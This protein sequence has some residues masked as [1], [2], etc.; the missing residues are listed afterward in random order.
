MKVLIVDEQT[1]PRRAAA[2]ALG[3]VHEVVEAADAETAAHAIAKSGPFDVVVVAQELPGVGELMA[4]ARREPAAGVVVVAGAPSADDAAHAL[5]TG[6][7]H[8]LAKPVTPALLRAA[9]AS[10]RPHAGH[11]G[12]ALR[13]HAVQALTLNGY[14]VDAGL[15]SQVL[16]DGTAVH[17]FTVAQVV[18]GWTRE[19]RVRVRPA[20]FRASGRPDLPPGGRLAATIARRALAAHLWTDGVVPPHDELVLGDVTPADVAEALRE[21]ID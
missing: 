13:D 7:R 18:A 2:L 10:A 9:V 19:V 5:A 21:D 4:T 16:K 8:Y 20:A 11:G 1:M 15:R 3:G 14:A 12:A 17:V 6:A